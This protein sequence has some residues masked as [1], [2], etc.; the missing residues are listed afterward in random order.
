VD[1]IYPEVRAIREFVPA[2]A[3]AKL[4]LVMDMHCPWVSGDYNEHAYFVGADDAEDWKELGLF[5]RILESVR[6]GPVPYRAANNLPFGKEW[7]TAEERA[8][9]LKSL[10]AW[11]LERPEVAFSCSLELPYANAEGMCVT[12]ESARGFGRDLAKAIRRYLEER[13]PTGARP[14]S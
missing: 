1:C 13:G 14:R 9:G 7:N 2:W 5:S 4:R 12:A 8:G 3:K 11:C 10:H 6:Q